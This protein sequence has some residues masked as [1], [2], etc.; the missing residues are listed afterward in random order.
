MPTTQQ[1]LPSA[2]CRSPLNHPPTQQSPHAPC[3]RYDVRVCQLTPQFVEEVTTSVWLTGSQGAEPPPSTMLSG[4]SEAPLSVS[5]L[6]SLFNTRG[7]GGPRGL[8]QSVSLQDAP[9]SDKG[10]LLQLKDADAQPAS[11]TSVHKGSTVEEA[12]GAP[13]TP[14]GPG[15]ASARVRNPQQLVLHAAERLRAAEESQKSRSMLGSVSEEGAQDTHSTLSASVCG[16]YKIVQHHS[17]TQ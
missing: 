4:V 8:L 6:P 12:E 13:G 9:R 16:S 17:S 15:S 5:A 14:A 3:C 11:G 1:H 10:L 2:I 7:T